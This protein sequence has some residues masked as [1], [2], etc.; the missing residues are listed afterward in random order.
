MCIIILKT[1]LFSSVK[2]LSKLNSY[3]I[4]VG[5]SD[6]FTFDC[7]AAKQIYYG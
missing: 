7:P 5:F 3:V 1:I 2:R 6:V 4:T